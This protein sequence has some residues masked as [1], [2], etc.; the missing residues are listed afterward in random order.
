MPKTKLD[1]EQIIVA[2]LLLGFEKIS[3]LDIS[4]LIE[5]FLRKNPEY[6]I[7]E[8][9][10]MHINEYITSKYDWISLKEGLDMNSYIQKNDST[11]R[12][13][14]EQ[15]AGKTIRKYLE[16]F[17]MEEFVLRKINH[18]PE[19]SE[20]D[21]ERLYCK[22]QQEEM[23]KLEEKGYLTT[24]WEGD[25]IYDD[26]KIIAL[27]DYGN[28]RLF[29]VNNEKELQRF[30]EELKSLR[31]D[32][33][34]LDDFLLT[35]D[36]TLPVW[37]ILNT[38]NLE[39]FCKDY[40][41]A[42]LEYGTTNVCFEKLGNKNGSILTENGKKKMRDMLSVWDDG[43]CIYITHP[44]HIFKGAKLITPDTREI[45]HVNWNHIDVE[46]MF[47]MN[48]AQIF[49]SSNYNE[50]FRYVHN[51]MESQIKQEAEK[52]NQDSTICHLAVVE[53]YRFEYENYYLVRGIIKRDY[54]GYRIAFNPE[55]KDTTPKSVLEKSLRFSGEEVPKIYC[56]KRDK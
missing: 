33:S 6:E 16:T 37:S 3:S 13:R 26:S 4:L 31:Y 39:Q 47:R 15:I 34:L 8:K 51:H 49:L 25:Y 28:V 38:E 41:R 35:Q 44:N 46:K 20:D 19:L 18:H 30:T 22:V 7:C 56:L 53:Q 10:S 24:Y 11:L 2:A 17:D 29:K 14:L 50:A 23:K 45:K 54:N 5:D 40:D 55:Y 21:I 12:K 27:S 32:I 9:G 48:Q 52:R 1:T 42:P 43:H 36:L